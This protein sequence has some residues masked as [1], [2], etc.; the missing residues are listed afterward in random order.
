MICLAL[1]L[2]VD[3]YP[4]IPACMCVCEC[5][6]VFS[7]LAQTYSFFWT[8]ISRSWC[9][10][11]VRGV[12]LGLPFCRRRCSSRRCTR[13]R[14]SGLRR[15]CALHSIARISISSSSSSNQSC[16]QMVKPRRISRI[17]RS[18]LTAR[19]ECCQTR[20]TV[21]PHWWSASEN[22][23][24]TRRRPPR[25][26]T[27]QTRLPIRLPP[28]PRP[29]PRTHRRRSRN[30]HPPALCWPLRVSACRHYSSVPR[31]RARW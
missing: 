17:S 11:S 9:R 3:V 31:R 21:R 7:S 22:Q 23:R 12:A 30:R 29:L 13:P 10:N 27:D 14:H 6:C 19:K 28:A 4:D 26:R 2:C 25:L 18:I 24:Q 16:R 8:P 5:V 20:T 15:R 1:C